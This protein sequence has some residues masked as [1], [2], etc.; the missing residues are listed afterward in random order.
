MNNFMR[1]LYSKVATH[2]AERPVE[3]RWQ[4]PE[5]DLGPG[6]GKVT[7]VCGREGNKAII[8]VAPDLPEEEQYDVFL[9]ELAH[10]RLHA[11]KVYDA[12]TEQRPDFSA[13]VL[14]PL[15]KAVY[16]EREAEANLQ[17]A[18]WA[19]YAKQH[20]G[21]SGGRVLRLLALLDMEQ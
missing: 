17:K 18:V 6:G 19:I 11:D 16:D 21:G 1:S 14:Q 3:V 20:A 10:A 7:G 8:E 12:L 9:H 15:R 4:L 13:P 5:Q 2:L